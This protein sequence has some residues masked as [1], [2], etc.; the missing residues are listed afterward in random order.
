MTKEAEI[1]EAVRSAYASLAKNRTIPLSQSCCE[2]ATQEKLLS[3]GYSEEELRSLPESVVSMSDG[4]GNPTGLGTI[5]EGE[6]VLDLGSGG[7][8]DVFLASR[9]VGPQGKVIGLDMTPEMVQKARENAEK[10]N[11][12]NVEFR[13]GEIESLPIEDGSVDVIISNCVICLSPDKGRVFAEMY[14]V[15]RPGGRLAIADEVALRPFSK[16]ESEDSSKW[17]SCV[18]GAITEKEYASALRNAG[19]KET[20]VK[21]LRHPGE[22]TPSVFSAFISATKA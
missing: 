20:Y 17:C 14:R 4:C 18:S 2:P 21:Q 15:M 16:E 10:A 11:L 8:I 6:T 12:T 13:L 7:G 1:R 19:F 9:K 3:Y 5:R 22:L